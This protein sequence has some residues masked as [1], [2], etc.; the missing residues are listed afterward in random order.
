M[1]KDTEACGRCSMTVVVDAVDEEEAGGRDPFG[2]DRIEVDEREMQRASPDAW[3]ARVSSR[4]DDAVTR[5]AW[6]R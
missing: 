4:I 3:V 2:D 1:A 5:L 6:S